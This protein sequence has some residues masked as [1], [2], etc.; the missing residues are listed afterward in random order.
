M[1]K[2]ARTSRNGS[3]WCPPDYF[4]VIGTRRPCYA[5]T[6]CRE[7]IVQVEAPRRLIEGGLPTERLLADV[8]VAKC[9]DGL[10]FHRQDGIYTRDRVD[11][12]RTVMA[13]WRGKVGFHLEPLTER[14]LDLIRSGE[15]VSAV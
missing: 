11:L 14:I 6:V 9:A 15:R 2:W 3:T 4:H 10:P 13:G 1:S 7:S 8:A 12:G 5:F